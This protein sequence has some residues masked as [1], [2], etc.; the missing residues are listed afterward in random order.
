[1]RN[2]IQEFMEDNDLVEGENFEIQ[3]NYTYGKSHI[4]YTFCAKSLISAEK[5]DCSHELGDL[6]QG[7]AHVVKIPFIPKPGEKYFYYNL[8][9]DE[10]EDNYFTGTST[11]YALIRSGW[12]FRSE[13]ECGKAIPKIK[14]E[15]KEMRG[16]K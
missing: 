8:A 3:E 11:E 9:L 13:A 6:I 10:T 12:M 4:T 14:K 2:Y 16:N 5:D 15:I 7:I 1:M